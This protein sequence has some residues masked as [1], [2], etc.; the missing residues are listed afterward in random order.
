[1]QA[2][3]EAMDHSMWSL[4]PHIGCRLSRT[5]IGSILWWG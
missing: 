4:R 1:M 2:V 3:T 5:P